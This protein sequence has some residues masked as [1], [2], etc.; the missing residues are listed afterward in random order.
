MQIKAKIST[1][2]GVTLKSEHRD[3][4]TLFPKLL[5]EI[6]T[7]ISVQICKEPRIVEFEFQAYRNRESPSN[8]DFGYAPR[9]PLPALLHVCS[10]SRHQGLMHYTKVLQRPLNAYHVPNT[11]I[12]MSLE[13]DTLCVLPRRLQPTDREFYISLR[14]HVFKNSNEARNTGQLSND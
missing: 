14:N 7:M 10:E 12:Y 13:N 9:G 4:F 8:S 2:G 1:D 6:R 3:R 11:I 5:V